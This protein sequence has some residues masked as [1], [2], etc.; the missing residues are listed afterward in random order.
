MAKDE[1]KPVEATREQIGVIWADFTAR[2]VE[3]EFSDAFYRKPLDEQASIACALL[4]SALGSHVDAQDARIDALT[5]SGEPAD[6]TGE[7]AYAA[8][9]TGD[10]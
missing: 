8:G 7:L 1:Q 2:T 3:V 4:E 10:A 9:L 5:V 6:R